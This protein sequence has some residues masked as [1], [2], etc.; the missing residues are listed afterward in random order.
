M[1]LAPSRLLI[2]PAAGRGTRLGGT[3]PKALALVN[4]KPMIQHVLERH[5][6]RVAAAVPI[7]QA[8]MERAIEQAARDAG[9]PV[10]PVV[11]ERATGMLDAI[12]LAAGEVRRAEP[13]CVWITWCDQLAIRPATLDALEQACPFASTVALALPTLVGSHPY[14]HFERD[15]AGRIVALRQR[16]EGDAMPAVGE[17]DAGLF[18]LSLRAYL[19]L[20]PVFDASFGERGAT[21]ERNFLPF[22]P[23]LEARHPGAVRTFPCRDA[24]EALGVNTPEDLARVEAD[25]RA[26]PPIAPAGGRP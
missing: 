18:A 26:Q 14:I 5:R 1:T 12:L 25:L 10:R 11:Q 7:V 3:T 21:G 15:A 9:V 2:V 23:W 22:I 19:D 20:L 13:S 6:G 17:S 24:I 8:G 16:R 4:G